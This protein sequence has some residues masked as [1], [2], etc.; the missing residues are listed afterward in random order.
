MSAEIAHLVGTDLVYSL[1]AIRRLTGMLT[2]TFKCDHK[3]HKVIDLTTED[4]QELL[5][6]LACTACKLVFSGI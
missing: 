5:G 3:W 4:A 6:I 1:N 2:F